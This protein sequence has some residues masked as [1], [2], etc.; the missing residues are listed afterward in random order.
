[1]QPSAAADE[2]ANMRE[3]VIAEIGHFYADRRSFCDRSGLR[4][5]VGQCVLKARALEVAWKALE[6]SE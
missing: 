4:E 3:E 5:I 1:M 6:S 2:L